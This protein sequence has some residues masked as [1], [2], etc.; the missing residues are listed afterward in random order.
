[1]EQTD[2]KPVRTESLPRIPAEWPGAFGLYKYSKAAV[3]H[4][5]GIVL[6]LWICV[7]AIG[8]LL[9]GWMRSSWGRVLGEVASAIISAMLAQF[10]LA[11]ARAQRLT[12]DEALVN[13]F[14]VVLR[15]ILT[16]IVMDVVLLLSL[17][18]LVIPFFFVLPRVVLAPYFTI[19]KKLGPIAAIRVSW[20]AT[21][22]HAGNIWNIV[23]ATVAMLLL[24]ITIIGIPFAAYFL[25]MYSAVWAVMYEF[26]TQNP[27]KQP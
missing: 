4:N 13:R 17:I 7:I 5:F 6:A 20:Q 27:T 10:Y 9:D 12:A 24:C 14:T 26:V 23:L 1:M 21:K 19:D 8:I 15:Y 2:Q 11:G 25:L 18:L 22:G 3:M 16:A